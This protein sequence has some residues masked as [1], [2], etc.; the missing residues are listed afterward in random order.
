MKNNSNKNNK[1]DVKKMA[2]C[3]L[4]TAFAMILSY[5]EA[6]IPIPFPVPGMKLGLANLAIIMV[7][8]LYSWKEAFLVSVMRIILTSL[9]FGTGMSF[10]FSIAGGVLSLIIMAL[11]KKSKLLPMFGVSMVGGVMHN[12]GQL[13]IAMIIIKTTKLG[14]YFAILMVTGA[15]T[16][17]LN[18]YLGSLGLKSL[19]KVIYRK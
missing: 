16:G 18:G 10:A 15:V 5:V 19:N 11:I 8:Y 2:L 17:I 14:Y 9:L 4:F 7:M 6:L 3:A 12:L 1:L 13:I